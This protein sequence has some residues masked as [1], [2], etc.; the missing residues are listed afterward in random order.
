VEGPKNQ[1]FDGKTPLAVKISHFLGSF[2]GLLGEWR[3][4]GEGA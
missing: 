3:R 4:L 1:L 2:L